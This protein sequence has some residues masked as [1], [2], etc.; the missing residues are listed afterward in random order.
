MFTFTFGMQITHEKWGKGK[1]F[2]DYLESR[3]ISS[4]LINKIS[5]EDQKFLLEIQSNTKYYE[6]VDNESNL[7]QALI[8]INQEMQ[9]HLFREKTGE[10]GFDIIPVEYQKNEYYAKV[11]IE[12]NPYSDTLKTIKQKK[13]AERLGHA[14]KSSINTKKLRKGDQ[15]SFIYTQR[16]RL[17]ERYSMPDIKVVNLISRAKESFIYVDEDGDGHKEG[18][19]RSQFTKAGDYTHLV[20]LRD[21]SNRLGMPLR[22]VRITSK[23]TYRRWHPILK[24]YRPHHGTDFGA[25]KGTP[26]LAVYGGK[27]TYAG[28]MGGYGKV[29]KIRHPRGYESLYAHQS[30]IRVHRGEQ[31]KKGQIIGYVGSTGRSTGPHLHFGLKR[32]RKWVDPM[33]HLERESM[34]KSKYNKIVIKNAKKNKTKLLAY[35][36]EDTPSYIWG[37]EHWENARLQDKEVV[38][39]EK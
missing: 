35:L 14:L 30:R 7:I 5:K 23:F 6:L 15:F 9:I 2:S 12:S 20:P 28:R 38:K 11:D 39:N 10:Y 13:V 36:K 31:V 4:S 16:T 22:H 1:T 17:G 26:L 19:E 21:R 24:R 27:V 8:P 3:G 18:A 29:V 37:E 32:Y 25:R 33:K 34:N